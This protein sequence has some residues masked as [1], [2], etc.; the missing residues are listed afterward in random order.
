MRDGDVVNFGCDQIDVRGC[1]CA[2]AA[3]DADGGFD[4]EQVASIVERKAVNGGGFEDGEE[5]GTTNGRGNSR[6]RRV[7]S[8]RRSHRD[9]NQILCLGSS[10][11]ILIGVN[12]SGFKPPNSFIVPDKLSGIRFKHH[13]FVRPENRRCNPI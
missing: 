12:S 10:V 4:G 6:S 7:A 8:S 5:G 11:N 3:L 9:A 13:R 1:A 2:S